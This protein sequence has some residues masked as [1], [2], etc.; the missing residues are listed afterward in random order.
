MLLWTAFT[1]VTL[2]F[3]STTDPTP[4]EMN[5]TIVVCGAWAVICIVYYYFPVYGGV[6][7]FTG[8]VA[9]IEIE[10]PVEKVRID[11][12]EVDKTDT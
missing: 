4:Q 6:H 12:R 2:M 10:T 9:N 11:L 7:W 8:P 1:V 5:Y 3:P